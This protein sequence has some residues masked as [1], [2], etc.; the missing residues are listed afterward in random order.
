MRNLFF[1]CVLAGCL[2]L[3]YA[4]SVTAQTELIPIDLSRTSPLP[5]PRV[6]PAQAEKIVVP[7][8]IALHLRNATLAEALD[9]LR[10]QSGVRLS[11]DTSWI[12]PG[13]LQ[14]RL[15]LDLESRSYRAAIRAIFAGAG[16]EATLGRFSSFPGIIGSHKWGVRWNEAESEAGALQA[17]QSPFEVQ[18]KSVYSHVSKSVEPR[19]ATKI[20]RTINESLSLGFQ[21]VTEPQF[22]DNCTLQVHLT[23]ATDEQGRS[24]L[25][26]EDEQ[27]RFSLGDGLDSLVSVELR[28]PSAGTRKL[29][30]VEGS[31]T[32]VVPVKR[33]TWEMADVL[34]DVGAARE[35]SSGGNTIRVELVRAARSGRE[36]DVDLKV[37]SPAN[38]PVQSPFFLPQFMISSLQ[39]HSANN[40]GFTASNRNSGK[41]KGDLVV[42]ARFQL[43]DPDNSFALNEKGVLFRQSSTVTEP[44]ALTFNAPTE[45]VQTE[46]P[47]S[48]RDVPLP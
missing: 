21:A 26:P 16:V 1:I 43:P 5:F 18:L 46:V 47:F 42:R 23:S 44:F 10:K 14:K 6:S 13:V 40:R 22:T 45:W 4:P 29:A 7:D 2:A 19:L 32:Y 20:E 39:L 38:G 17:G 11:L 41:A 28:P 48:F 24:L 15:S 34:N 30:R 27:S 35:F 31:A 3:V 33:S 36:I 37:S 9:E 12:P 25:L 8:S